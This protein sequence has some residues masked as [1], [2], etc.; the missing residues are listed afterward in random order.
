MK[1]LIKQEN[2]KIVVLELLIYTLLW[3]KRTPCPVRLFE[4]K[5]AEIARS[6]CYEAFL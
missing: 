6:V 1:M 2:S 3:V 5:Q 4:L